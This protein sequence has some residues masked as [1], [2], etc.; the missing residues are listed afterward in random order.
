MILKNLTHCPKM[1]SS[2][3]K[4]NPS[5]LWLSQCPPQTIPHLTSAELSTNTNLERIVRICCTA[6]AHSLT[7]GLRFN[8]PCMIERNTP[9]ALSRFLFLARDS[10]LFVGLLIGVFVGDAG[11]G[12]CSIRGLKR[13]EGGIERRRR[14]ICP[15]IRGMAGGVVFGIG[16][17]GGT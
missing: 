15:G 14:L 8:D 5:K 2:H 6:P 16:G 7:L 11:S 4:S 13:V 17:T 3:S 9:L 1:V 12:P 10:S